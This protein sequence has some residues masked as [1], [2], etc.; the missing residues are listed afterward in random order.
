MNILRRWIRYWFGFSRRET[1]GFLVLM[2]LIF[3]ILFSKSIYETLIPPAV[4]DFDRESVK[5]DSLIAVLEKERQANGE[6]T[7]EDTLFGFDPN[8]VSKHQLAALGFSEQVINRIMNYRVKGGRFFIKRDLLKIYG[9][10]TSFYERLTPFIQLPIAKS[11]PKATQEIQRKELVQAK[12]DTLF[13]LNTVDSIGL[14]KVY[15]I[16]PVLSSRIIRYRDKLGGFVDESQLYEVYGLDSTVVNRLSA[17]A[18]IMSGFVPRKLDINHDRENDLS[19]HPYLS[20]SEA[21]AIVAYRFQH[22]SFLTV[23]DIRKIQNISEKKFLKIE[24]YL[25]IE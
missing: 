9:M 19:A 6:I 25:S 7:N 1:N 14:T 16:G 17:V 3:L 12:R 13:D 22:G 10:D 11:S 5:L 20:R 18:Y 2:P 8:T 15:G 21:K 24:P 4:K 23:Q